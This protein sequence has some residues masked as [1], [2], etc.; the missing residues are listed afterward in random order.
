MTDA[1]R[2]HHVRAGWADS[3][4]ERGID[5]GTSRETRWEFEFAKPNLDPGPRRPELVSFETRCRPMT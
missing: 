5:D 3:L 2:T 1:D 4:I